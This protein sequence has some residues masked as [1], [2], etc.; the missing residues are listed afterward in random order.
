MTCDISSSKSVTEELRKNG[1]EG[2]TIKWE[3]S[4]I[5]CLSSALLRTL[6]YLSILHQI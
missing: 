6:M 1:T 4:E 2:T 5:N 3:R